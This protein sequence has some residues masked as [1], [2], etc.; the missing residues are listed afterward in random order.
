MKE[1]E[2]STAD[3]KSK[4][5]FPDQY[6][7]DP[8]GVDRYVVQEK[9]LFEWKTPSKVER[10]WK[11]SDLAQLILL[12]A[13]LGLI[14][15]LLGDPL[16]FLVFMSGAILLIIYSMSKPTFLSCKITTLGIKIEDQY[17]FWSQLAQFWMEPK[18]KTHFLFFRD[19][20]SNYRFRRLIITEADEEKIKTTIGTYLLYKKPQQTQWEKFVQ[21][22]LEKTPL[23]DEVF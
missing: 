13:L 21:K 12:V 18:G 4:K 17:Y 14:L 10:N 22:V 5:S 2:T 9:T 15:L 23:A 8:Y 20:L 1:K 16:L 19:V 11:R 6:Y 3:E 7:V